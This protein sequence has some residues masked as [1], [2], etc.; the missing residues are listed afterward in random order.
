MCGA[1]RAAWGRAVRAT[2]RPPWLSALALTIGSGSHLVFLLSPVHMKIS[3]V[4]TIHSDYKNLNLKIL[5]EFFNEV[6]S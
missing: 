5:L 1:R 6:L 4:W 2:G 3:M